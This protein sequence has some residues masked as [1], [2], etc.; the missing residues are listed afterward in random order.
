MAFTK[1]YLKLLAIEGNEIP[2]VF[3][4]FAMSQEVISSRFLT[5]FYLFLPVPMWPT[6]A[7]FVLVLSSYCFKT[8]LPFHQASFKVFIVIS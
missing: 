1:K 5:L 6:V 2:F 3:K 4:K 7:L 8:L